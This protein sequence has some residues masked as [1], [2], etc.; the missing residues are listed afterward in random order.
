MGA[1]VRSRICWPL[2]NRINVSEGK[3]IGNRN[4]QFGLHCRDL[5]FKLAKI[6]PCPAFLQIAQLI[7]DHHF[8]ALLIV[9]RD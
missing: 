1:G 4:L 6:I 5:V 7:V 9:V 3:G 8:V 2:K